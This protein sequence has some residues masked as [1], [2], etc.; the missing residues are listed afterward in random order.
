MKRVYIPTGIVNNPVAVQ[1][2]DYAFNYRLNTRQNV[3]MLH[4]YISSQCGRT[5]LQISSAAN[6]K[7]EILRKLSAFNLH[8]QVNKI[9]N[10][11]HRGDEIN[12]PVECLYQGSK[13]FTHSG[14]FYDLYQKSPRDV[15]AFV[16]GKNKDGI[17]GFS[18]FSCGDEWPS[19]PMKC[20]YN[21]LYLNAVFNCSFNNSPVCKNMVSAIDRIVISDIFEGEVTCNTQAYSLALFLTLHKNNVLEPLL[22]DKYSFIEYCKEI[23][24]LK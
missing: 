14:P 19:N 23:E 1:E 9:Y 24:N 4:E 18:L 20:F 2:V 10:H 11:R 3:H 15:K 21:W 17:I 13:I 22:R 8:L 5:P 16:K 7:Q 12:R 6:G